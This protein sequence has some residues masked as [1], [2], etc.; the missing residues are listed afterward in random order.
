MGSG[1]HLATAAREDRRRRINASR[2]VDRQQPREGTPIGD[3]LKKGEWEDTIGLSRGSRTCKT[4]CLAD[5]HCKLVAF[6]L[7]PGNIADISMDIPP[8]GAAMPACRLIANKAYDADSLRNWLKQRRIS[9][10]IPSTASHGTPYALDKP[11]YSRRSGIGP[12]FYRLK[13]GRRVATRYN[14]HVSNYFALVVKW[15]K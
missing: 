14:R 3:R 8:L 9:A 10:V 15:T 6:T 2:V 7:T 4:H 5:D 12:F 1:W 11:I 13:N